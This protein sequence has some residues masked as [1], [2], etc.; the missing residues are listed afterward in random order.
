MYVV[1]FR[2]R[3]EPDNR[4]HVPAVFLLN[5]A[6]VHLTLPLGWQTHL[7]RQD[8]VL[9]IYLWSVSTVRI[10]AEVQNLDRRKRTLETE[11]LLGSRPSHR[12]D[13][14]AFLQLLPDL[15]CPGGAGGFAFHVEE[16]GDEL[17]CAADV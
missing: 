4:C 12:T 11:L 2:W 9:R 14:P 15:A 1:N 13:N 7:A 6:R 16:V 8:D 17:T 5:P 3:C 10:V